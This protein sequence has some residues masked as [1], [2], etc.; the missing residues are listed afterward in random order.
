[1]IFMVYESLR[2]AIRPDLAALP[3]EKLETV[4]EGSAI[5]AEAMEN[6]LSSLGNIAKTVLPSVLPAV[7]GIA[8]TFVGGP[9][10]A[11]LGSKLGQLAG[12]AIGG[13]T[14]QPSVPTPSPQVPAAG[15]L[16]RTIARPETMQAL[17]SMLMGQLGRPNVQVGSTSVPVGAF[18]NLLGVLANQAGSQYNATI[19]AAREG[20]PEYMADYAG[21]T[22]GDPAVAADRA[23][24]LYELLENTKIEQESSEATEAAEYAR[25]E[26]EM[27]AAESDYDAMDLA[28]LY[29]STE[30]VWELEVI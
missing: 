6:W 17:T 19:S 18:T 9:V 22:K 4:L 2:E 27:E 20:V 23:E 24:A 13:S 15:G 21:E 5:D 8:G 25:F 12:G 3:A 10:G 11:A 30:S 7:G 16:L 28:D 26:S 29:E 14:G 1:L